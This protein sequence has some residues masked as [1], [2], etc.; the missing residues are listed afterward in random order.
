MINALRNAD[1][2]NKVGGAFKLTV[3]IQK[4]L[5]ELI[6]GSRPLIDN[7]E[8]KGLLEIV[9]QEILED[10]IALDMSGSTKTEKISE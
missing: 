4:R 3:L 8:G 6:Q 2:A 5:V 1:L 7:S 10:K 9:V